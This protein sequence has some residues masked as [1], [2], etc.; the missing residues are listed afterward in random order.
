MSRHGVGYCANC[1]HVCCPVDKYPCNLCNLVPGNEDHWAPQPQ[2]SESDPNGISQHEPGAKLD[3][4]KNRLGLVFSGFALALQ[5]VGA[6]GTYGANKYTDEGWEAVPD[7]N[8][9]YTDAMLRHLFKEFSGEHLDQE[10]GFLH[11][12]HAAWN[13]LARLEK[14][15]EE[16][17]SDDATE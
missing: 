2:N 8:K 1:V 6:V 5:A 7:A 15:I 14:I 11:A 3:A 13:A 10:T 12:A 9:R 16:G 4:G 17:S